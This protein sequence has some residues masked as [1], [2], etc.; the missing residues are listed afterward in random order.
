MN[1]EIAISKG[2]CVKRKGNLNKLFYIFPIWT[3]FDPLYPYSLNS[4]CFTFPQLSLWEQK[5][6]VSMAHCAGVYDEFITPLI[7]LLISTNGITI[8]ILLE[9]KTGSTCLCLTS[10]R[11]EKEVNTLEF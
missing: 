5:K 3:I 4:N 8:E 6:Y 7:K 9:S 1:N 2:H 10:S 11:R